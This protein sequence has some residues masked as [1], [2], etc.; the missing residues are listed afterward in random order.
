[1]RATYHRR[2]E[3]GIK[4]GN[5]ELDRES[6]R[7]QLGMDS[8]TNPLRTVVTCF[9]GLRELYGLPKR[10][11]TEDGAVA[12]ATPS[13]SKAVP[14]DSGI[15]RPTANEGQERGN[16]AEALRVQPEKTVGR[17]PRRGR[18]ASEANASGKAGGYAD[19]G[20]ASGG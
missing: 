17:K 8:D 10:E 6:R 12:E 15:L 18:I 1:M 7:A 11:R 3:A 5:P 13:T 20:T 16:P 19:G 2:C 9:T 4:G 14:A